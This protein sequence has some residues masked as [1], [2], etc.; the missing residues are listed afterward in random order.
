M[1]FDVKVS[2]DFLSAFC[3]VT[4]FTRSIPLG[5]TTL[6]TTLIGRHRHPPSGRSV[7]RFVRDQGRQDVARGSLVPSDR[8]YRRAGRQDQV[9]DRECEPDEDRPRRYVSDENKG[10]MDG[11]SDD[12]RSSSEADSSWCGHPFRCSCFPSRH[13]HIL[14][15]VQNIKIAR[16][17]IV[18]LILGSP[19]GEF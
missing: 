16:D 9:Y 17:A 10:G 3:R 1:G 7:P 15:S 13:V 8:A 11:W 2:V 4:P 14:G 12:T 5:L 19:P 6:A 18:S